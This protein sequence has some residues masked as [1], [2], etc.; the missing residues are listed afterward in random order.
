MISAGGAIRHPIDHE[1]MLMSNVGEVAPGTTK[2]FNFN[3][4]IPAT[5]TNYTAIGRVTA[6]Y[7]II[8]IST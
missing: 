5:I 7:F 4:V 3:A 6:R 1:Y 8:K 2:D